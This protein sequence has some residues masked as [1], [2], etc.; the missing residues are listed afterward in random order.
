MRPTYAIGYEYLLISSLILS[1]SFSLRV[2]HANSI[3]RFSNSSA[4]ILFIFLFCVA[5]F[6]VYQYTFDSQSDDYAYMSTFQSCFLSYDGNT[7]C[8]DIEW[9]SV[10]NFFSNMSRG[11]P[12]SIIGFTPVEALENAK[13]FPAFLEVIIAFLF[14]IW[15][16]IKLIGRA[17]VDLNVRSALYL[18]F[19]P[20]LFIMILAHYPLGIFN[21]GS[22][23]CYKQSLAPAFYFYPLFLLSLS[24]KNRYY[25]SAHNTSHFRSGLS[26][27]TIVL[28]HSP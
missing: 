12:F 1:S 25:F 18:C 21:P 4:I 19:L 6:V 16:L 13:Y 10:A 7:N 17:K 24:V 22:A 28:T 15:L 11:I 8:S 9:N 23:I 20:A 26:K 2:K 14:L 27:P 5:S 3:K